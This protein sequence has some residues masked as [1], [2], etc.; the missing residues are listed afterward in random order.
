MA[1]YL[2]E[3]KDDIREYI[4]DNN[5]YSIDLEEI[6][7]GNNWD[8]FEEELNDTLWCE[9]SVTGNGSGSYYFNRAEAQEQVLA[10]MADVVEAYREFGC[11]IGDDLENEDY[12][13]MDVTARC[14]FLGWAISDIIEELKDAYEEE[15]EDDEEEDED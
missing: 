15:H 13:R 4:E 8:S 1:N 14:Y 2:T 3:L 9:D 5:G 11:N 7:S 6:G 12:E 10:H